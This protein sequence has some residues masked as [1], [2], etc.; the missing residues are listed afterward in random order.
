MHWLADQ[1]ER[2]AA[3]ADSFQ[4]ASSSALGDAPLPEPARQQ[5]ARRAYLAAV[6]ELVEHVAQREGVTACFAC[7]DGLVLHSAGEAPD[8][9]ALSAMTQASLT[10]AREAALALSL[11]RVKQLV[12]VGEEHKLALLVVGLLAIGILSPKDVQLGQTLAR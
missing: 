12:L 3:R 10:A 9:E 4:A 5:E 7:H 6:R 8:F 1:V 2:V 11:G